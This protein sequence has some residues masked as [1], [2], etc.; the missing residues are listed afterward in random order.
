M[1]SSRPVPESVGEVRPSRPKGKRLVNKNPLHRGVL[2]YDSTGI[3]PVTREMVHARARELALIAGRRPPQVQQANYEQA[4]RE[5][6]GESDI[7]RQAAILDALPESKR[8]DTIP[9]SNR[10]QAVETASE[11]EDDEGRSETEQLVDEGA[12]EA[13][14]NRQFEAT[15]AAAKTAPR[16]A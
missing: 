14:R 10:H 8:W 12:M 1:E 5:L 9:G 6:T 7:D 4:K 11:E 3:G 2:T 15:R 16:K 13:E